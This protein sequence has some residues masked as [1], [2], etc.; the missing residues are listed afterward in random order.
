MVWPNSHENKLLQPEWITQGRIF[1]F[2]V[3]AVSIRTYSGRKNKKEKLLEELMKYILG[4]T[5][6]PRG[7]A[8]LGY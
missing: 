7:E 8:D 3:V 2:S 1:S 4:C 5:F 6:S